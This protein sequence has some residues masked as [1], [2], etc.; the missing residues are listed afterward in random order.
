M[1]LVDEYQEARRQLHLARLRRVLAI[2]AMA[3][4]GLSQREIAEEL[5]ISQPAVSMQLKSTDVSSLN[6]EELL[7]AATPVLKRVA[8]DHGF[9]DLAVFGSVARHEARADSDIDLLVKA[10]PGTTITRLT[11][12]ASVFERILGRKVDLITYGALEPGRGDDVRREA[13]LL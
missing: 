4:V 2:R 7:E 6:P 8:E 13:V 12:L 1:T 3:A 9:T 11:H 10:P 5:G